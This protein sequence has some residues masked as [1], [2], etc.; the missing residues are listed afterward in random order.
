M[1][2]IRTY[3]AKNTQTHSDMNDM[4]AGP[5]GAPPLRPTFLKV[6]CILSFI[7]LGLMIIFGFLGYGGMKMMAS[8]KMEEIIA[9]SGDPTAMTK[10]E[11]AQAKMAETGLTMDQ[12]ASLS[13][14]GAGI[15]VLA[16][17]GVILMWK[18]KRS[19]FYLYAV[20]QLVGLLLPI[21]MGGKMQMSGSGL[22]GPLLT[23]LF[24]ILFGMNLKHMR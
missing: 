24:I 19:G 12:L 20:V 1:A 22:I 4:T 7:W 10:W 6:L 17:I 14:M 3:F 13:L 8:G 18:L 11:E 21:L 15:A 2:L 5:M 9:Q 23:I 16:L